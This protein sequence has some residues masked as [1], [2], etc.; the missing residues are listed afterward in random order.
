MN[1]NQEDE[2]DSQLQRGDQSVSADRNHHADNRAADGAEL[3]ERQKRFNFRQKK[4]AYGTE[5][6]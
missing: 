1:Q 3:H 2:P 4:G 5:Y 6:P